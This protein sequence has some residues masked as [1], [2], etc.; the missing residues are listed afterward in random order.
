MEKTW[1]W[2]GPKDPVTLEKLRSIGVE[3]VVTSLY[4]LS[5]GTIWGE[6]SI[7]DL[8]ERIESTGLR[9]SVV[10]S[11][12]VP[13]GVKYGSKDRDTLIG[14]YLASL[15]NLGR[16][17]IRTVCYNFMPVI[18]WIRTDLEYQLPDG[19]ST[20]YFDYARMAYFDIHILRRPE[21]EADYPPT[22]LRKVD[23]IVHSDSSEEIR[24]TLID[25]I[26][27]KTQGFICGNF[28]SDETEPVRRFR[29]LLAP[30]EGFTKDDLRENL[31]YF[32]KAAMPVCDRYRI[33]MCI[34][35]DDPPLH[36]VFGLPRI[37][38]GRE[39]IR[40]ILSN[41]DNPHNGLTFCA[42]TLCL[43]EEDDIVQMA[44]EFRSR[45]H[46]IHLRSCVSLPGGDFMEAPHTGG[47]ARLSELV[48]IFEEDER[49][50]PM[51]VDHGRL[52]PDDKGLSYPPGYSYLGRLEALKQVEK[53]ISATRR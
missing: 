4:D 43:S 26:I 3:G 28:S 5:A 41:V 18:D 1:R 17:G 36:R 52:M 44:R 13:E 19:S 22:V 42:G 12:P 35:P 7:R 39:D 8:Q 49:N 20:L 53:M 11:L 29:E 33:D 50:L 21:A 45:T 14:N 32:L 30:Y 24:R 10:E 31:R 37:V 9:W 48:S 6:D 51:R 16:R 38:T 40:W 25:S 15:E 27:L 47:K 46:F 34:H 23:A 2:F